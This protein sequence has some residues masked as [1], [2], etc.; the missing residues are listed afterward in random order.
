M[1]LV[2]NLISLSLDPI[3]LSSCTSKEAYKNS[4]H[5][6]R[7]R[8]GNNAIE[9]VEEAFNIGDIGVGWS[10][11][12]VKFFRFDIEG[13]SND[14]RA[15]SASPT[16][17]KKRKRLI[18]AIQS[19]SRGK[20]KKL[21]PPTWP[22]KSMENFCD[23]DEKFTEK[24]KTRHVMSAQLQLVSRCLHFPSDN[25]IFRHSSY[26]EIKRPCQTLLRLFT[27]C[28]CFQIETHS[29]SSTMTMSIHRNL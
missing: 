21:S 8:I 2:R 5:N 24:P 25:S 16:R 23:A 12:V 27:S 6:R 17:E 15:T 22:H 20:S 29:I 10:G 4:C 3:T 11:G 14:W 26:V 7:S 28:N 19:D 18:G 9:I 1:P 13:A